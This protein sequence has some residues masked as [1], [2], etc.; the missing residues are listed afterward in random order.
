MSSHYRSDIDAIKGLAIIAVI[1]YHIGMLPMGF[2]GVESFLVVNGFLII[3]PLV[4]QLQ[5][6]EF[7]PLRWLSKRIFRLWPIVLAAST[8]CL[9]VGYQMMIPD[10][11]ENLAES[12]VASNLFANNIL[13][14]IT[15]ANYWDVVNEYKP[16]MQMW[17]I[18]V[19]VQFYLLYPV[20]LVILKKSFRRQSVKRHFWLAAVSLIGVISLGMYLLYP[21]TF[22]NKFY[23]VQ[24]RVWEFSLGGV[25]GMTVSRLRISGHTIAYVGYALLCV[26]FL[27]GFK[28]LSQVDTLTI[29][30]METAPGGDMIKITLTI[31]VA[32]LTSMLLQTDVKTG[33]LLPLLGKISLSLFVWHQ[34]ILSFV[35]YGWISSFNPLQI[36]IYLLFTLFISL[37]SHKYIE[38]I[39]V[40]RLSSRLIISTLFV[41]STGCAFAIYRNAGVVRDVPELG[42]TR[43]NPYAN[44]NTEYIDQ[45]YALQQP[46]TSSGPHVLI[47]GN[48]FARDFACI[49][50]EYDVDNNLEMSYSPY[51]DNIDPSTLADADYLFIFGPKD[52]IPAK[53]FS[54]LKPSCK[55]YGI[56]TKSFGKNFGIY[57]AR[58]NTPDYF[59]QTIPS[60]PTVDSINAKWRQQ[61]GVENFIDIMEAAKL[62]NGRVRIFTPDHKVISFDCRHLTPDG[63][64]FCST[65]LSLDKIFT[66]H[67]NE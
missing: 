11:Y 6:G 17:Y 67:S 21:D 14:A 5:T 40:Q 26:L 37:L 16:L 39:K 35:R 13:A 7:S 56:G 33:L 3:P 60:N 22:S 10:D 59:S 43:E 64:K 42:I 44:H 19:I 48:S 31:A 8:V 45:I 49:I 58:R 41:L 24:Y 55:I 38:R 61:W 1:F 12:V 23:Y 25:A 9:F 63:C 15:T 52:A 62:S 46:F 65:R 32:L 57:Y 29:V 50:S 2:L 30:G 18:G 20:I 47:V 66:S 4:Y 53:L 36:A 28:S 54:K 27:I 34:V 51:V